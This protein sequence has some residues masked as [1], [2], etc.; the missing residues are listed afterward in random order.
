MT[1][2]QPIPTVLPFLLAPGEGERIWFTNAEMMI[3]STAATTGGHLGL[4]GGP[5][6]CLTFAVP[7]IN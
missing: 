4:I 5:A 3:K 7:P 1:D 2:L 6:R